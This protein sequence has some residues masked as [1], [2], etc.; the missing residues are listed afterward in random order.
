[1]VKRKRKAVAGPVM[2]LSLV[3]LVLIATAAAGDQRR[4][5]LA[6]RVMNPNVTC[7]HAQR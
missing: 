7:E 3:S 4:S 5:T 6:D 1:M 2:W